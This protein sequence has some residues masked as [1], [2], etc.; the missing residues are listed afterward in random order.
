MLEL[1]TLIHDACVRPLAFVDIETTG[2]RLGIDRITEIGVIEI[3]AN[4][5]HRWSTLLDPLR[6]IP[7]FVQR[8]TGITDAMVR[9]APTFDEIAAD[10]ACRLDGKLFIAHNARFDHGF[11]NSEFDRIG[12]RFDSDVLCTVRLSRALF[13]RE[14]RHGLDA[15]AQRLQLTPSGR[16][17]AL[18]DADLLWQFWQ[19]IHAL[20]SRDAIDATLARVVRAGG[21]DVIA[22]ALPAGSGVYAFFDAHGTPLYVGKSAKLRQR[23]RAQL[24]G[25]RRSKRDMQL[26]SQ[27]HEVRVYPVAGEVGLLLADAHWNMVLRPRYARRQLPAPACCTVSWP[28]G[29]PVALVEQPGLERVY[30]FHVL[31]A[32]QYLGSASDLAGARALFD[33][34]RQT[35][36][37]QC[38]EFDHD[39][40]ACADTTGSTNARAA[41]PR[42][43]GGVTPR[44]N[45]AIFRILAQ[46]L[47]RGGLL[48]QQLDAD[49]ADTAAR[50]DI[51]QRRR[52]AA[53]CNAS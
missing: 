45:A 4:G 23:V 38:N 29:G 46:R 33:A 14:T 40:L 8:L 22:N 24:F 48:V 25:E 30:G 11:L 39:R 49:H 31:D 12:M 20:H 53:E 27:V 6:P 18:A 35:L 19:R 52:I 15:I 51:R 5:V 21:A 16:H 28:Y 9:G 34:R 17:R 37:S 7:D 41:Q 32:W 10:L 13:P 44:F 36:A 26:A 50:A 42:T 2:G 47:S 3:D 1:A 43:L